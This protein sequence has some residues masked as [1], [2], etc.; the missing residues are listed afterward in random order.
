M[1]AGTASAAKAASHASSCRSSSR[2]GT[3]SEAAGGPLQGVGGS[4]ASAASQR[5][6]RFPLATGIGPVAPWAVSGEVAICMCCS[7]QR[8]RQARRGPTKAGS[9]KHWPTAWRTA[10]M[11]STHLTAACAPSG[12]DVPSFLL[13]MSLET[14]QT[15]SIASSAAAW[16][17]R[18]PCCCCCCCGSAPPSCIAALPAALAAER[19]ASSGL[20]PASVAQ[21]FRASTT[22][23]CRKASSQ[24]P[25]TT[26]STSPSNGPS[27]GAADR[28]PM[29]EEGMA[30][31]EESHS[32]SS[33][34]V[35]W[36]F[37]RSCPWPS[38]AF[39]ITVVGDQRWS[40]DMYSCVT[41]LMLH[42]LAC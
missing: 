39:A 13:F 22:M 31:T 27:E 38:G 17:R 29:A 11:M 7:T 41:A 36:C 9:P 25:A 37:C 30:A 20:L 23:G 42:N 40:A 32:F 12:P 18:F 16:E 21:G 6:R 14:R 10:G 28:V 3:H 2:R 33:A 19:R 8:A 15:A 35:S 4:R 26:A 24:R 5:P 1:A 34:E